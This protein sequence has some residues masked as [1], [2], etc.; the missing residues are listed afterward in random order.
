MPLRLHHFLLVLGQILEYPLVTRDKLCFL[1]SVIL[2]A[3]LVLD[4]DAFEASALGPNCLTYLPSFGSARVQLV[5]DRL[6]GLNG[7]P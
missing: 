3:V 6:M 7:S 1:S 5:N 4:T 2:E